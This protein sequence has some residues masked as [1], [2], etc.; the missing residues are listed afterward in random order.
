MGIKGVDHVV[1]RVKDIDEGIATYRD[2]FGMEL[3]RTAESEAL[4]IKQAFFPLSD[5]GY[6]EVVAPTN[7]QGAVGRAVES[8]GEGIHTIAMAVDD[9][10]AAI[11]AMQAN[12][13]QLIGAD[14]PAGQVFIHPRSAHGVLV[15]LVEKK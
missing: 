15:Q 1:V 12:D 5:G 9:M 8:R 6:I 2:K 13:V 14:N 11:E 4:G 7:D 3:E 10:K